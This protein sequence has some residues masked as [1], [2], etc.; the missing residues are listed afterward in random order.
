MKRYLHIDF[1]RSAA[2][3]GVIIIHVFSDN[4]TSSLNTFIW[5]YLHFIIVAFIFCSGYVMYALYAPRLSGVASIIGWYKKRLIRLVLPFYYYLIAHYT[6]MA[7]FPS[8][9]SGLGLKFNWKFIF[10]SIT[11]VGGINLNWLP[12]LFL[13]LA[14]VFPIL[15]MLLQKKKIIFWGYIIFASITTLAFTVWNFPYAYYREVM[16]IPWSLILVLPWYFVK[17]EQKNIKVKPY[18]LLSIVGAI[19][20]AI[21]MAVWS[22]V[23][24]SL[25][26]IDNKY[27]PNLFYISYE[28]A[29]SFALVALSLLPFFQKGKI[30]SIYQFISRTSYSLFFIHYIALDFILSI[31]T[32][33]KLHLSVWYQLVF[34]LSVSL[35]IAW[36]ISFFQ[37]KKFFLQAHNLPF[38]RSS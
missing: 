5:N 2:I 15:V 27:P 7:I 16:W 13:E 25:T 21:L 4:L 28:T 37:S 17:H 34:V 12:L 24:R 11:L 22:F 6:L 33:F 8:F 32:N 18:I 23:G 35:V 10:E 30:T 1:L 14:V 9:F 36:V 31:N 29:G 19:V 38:T 3:L 20:F 26:L